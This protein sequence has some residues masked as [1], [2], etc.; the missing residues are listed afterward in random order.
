MFDK[1]PRAAPRVM[2]HWDDAGMDARGHFVCRVCK[3]AAW[4]RDC[5]ATDFKRGI[6]CP[7]CNAEP[8]PG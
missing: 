8:Q 1:P 4:Y 5:T 3:Y 6:P 7:M 2:M